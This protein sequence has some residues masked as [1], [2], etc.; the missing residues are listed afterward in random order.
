MTKGRWLMMVLPICLMF[1]M[2]VYPCSTSCSWA[3][4]LLNCILSFSFFCHAIF[5]LFDLWHFVGPFAPLIIS[6][7]S[8]IHDEWVVS[9]LRNVIRVRHVPCFTSDLNSSRDLPKWNWEFPVGVSLTKYLVSTTSYYWLKI[10]LTPLL[11][12]FK[13]A[14]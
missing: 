4:C 7:S 13:K 5:L 11:I 8:S 9:S 10:N 6:C 14:F 1:S 2:F 3:S 12:L